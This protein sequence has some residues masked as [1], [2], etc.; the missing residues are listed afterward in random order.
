M[1][2]LILAAGYG[3]RLEKDLEKTES[4]KDLIGIPKPLL[5]IAGS[6]LISHW[7]RIITNSPPLS[8]SDV[9]IVVND[10]NID[11]F[12]EWSREHYPQVKMVSD[13]TNCNDNRIGAVACIA[14]AVRHFNINDDLL[15]IGGDTLFYEDFKLN[16]FMRKFE[17]KCSQVKGAMV[18]RCL[19]GDHETTK[20]GILEIDADDRVTSFLEKPPPHLTNSR[21]SVSSSV[22]TLLILISSAHASMC[23]PVMFSHFCINS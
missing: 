15:V 1:K 23:L 14:T 12:T 20:Y 18:T 4:H 6:P 19:C 7:M 13:G 3:T 11:K 5:P 2:V 8:P 21:F 22:M 10:S 17:S 16:D 9:H